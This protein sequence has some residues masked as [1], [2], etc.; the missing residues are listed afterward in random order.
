MRR[1]T[2]S[3]CGHAGYILRVFKGNKLIKEG[4]AETIK[5]IGKISSKLLNS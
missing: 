4:H 5:D 3:R 2:V 1:I